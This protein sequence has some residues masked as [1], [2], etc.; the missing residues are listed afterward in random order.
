[1]KPKESEKTLE[2]IKEAI[3]EAGTIDGDGIIR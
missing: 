2:A 1:M 3:K